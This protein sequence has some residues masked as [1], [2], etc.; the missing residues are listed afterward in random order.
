MHPVQCMQMEIQLNY[1][2]TIHMYMYVH[3]QLVKPLVSSILGMGPGQYVH[4]GFFLHHTAPCPQIKQPAMYVGSLCL[5]SML[6]KQ[7]SFIKRPVK[8]V[9]TELYFLVL[10]YIDWYEF[11]KNVKLFFVL[12]GLLINVEWIFYLTIKNLP[13]EFSKI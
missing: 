2:Q 6:I 11:K 4:V 3:T 7:N 8:S 13:P 5:T 10:L 1:S 12:S 9:F